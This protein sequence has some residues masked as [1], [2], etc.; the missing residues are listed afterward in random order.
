MRGKSSNRWRCGYELLGSG[1]RNMHSIILKSNLVALGQTGHAHQNMAQR[2]ASIYRFAYCSIFY[3]NRKLK[4]SRFLSRSLMSEIWRLHSIIILELKLLELKFRLHHLLVLRLLFVCLIL[5]SHTRQ[6]SRSDSWLSPQGVTPSSA[7]R[8]W[9]QPGQSMHINPLNYCPDTQVWLCIIYFG[10]QS[11]QAGGLGTTGG[12]SQPIVFG[13]IQGC[14]WH[15]AGDHV[16]V[17]EL[18]SSHARQAP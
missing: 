11:F 13:D 17:K 8:C 12:N 9:D 2:T 10:A 3:G 1:D 18:G 7:Q 14:M 4:L 6:H 15:D 5:G 16:W